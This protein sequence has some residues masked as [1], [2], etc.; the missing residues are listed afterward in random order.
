[1]LIYWAALRHLNQWWIDA[2]RST[3]RHAAAPIIGFKGLR[4]DGTPISNAHRQPA[5]DDDYRPSPCAWAQVVVER[6]RCT[7]GKKDAYNDLTLRC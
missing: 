2:S 6:Q 5:E 3:P 1:V 4:R 7:M